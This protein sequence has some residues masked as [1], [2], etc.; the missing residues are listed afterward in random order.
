MDVLKVVL[1]SE[2]L[3]LS[4]L[5]RSTQGV[6]KCLAKAAFAATVRSVPEHDAPGKIE[7]LG[8]TKPSERTK[9]QPMESHPGPGPWFGL[10]R[11][12]RE[13]GARV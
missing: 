4:L 2:P 12:L 3:R 13:G 6:L 8:L 7:V 5:D 10:L 9:C 11:Y 1:L